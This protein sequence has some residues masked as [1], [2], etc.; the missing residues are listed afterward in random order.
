MYYVHVQDHQTEFPQ[1]PLGE[2]K[3]LTSQLTATPYNFKDDAYYENVG[4]ANHLSEIM[5][6]LSGG[7]A[8]IIEIVGGRRSGKTEL[9]K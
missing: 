1:I 5:K 2:V 9:L 7:K 6:R 3:N 8:N 4:R